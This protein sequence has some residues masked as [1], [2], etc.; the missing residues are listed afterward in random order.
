MIANTI[1]YLSA[2]KEQLNVEALPPL[3]RNRIEW[4]DIAKGIGIILVVMGH[5]GLPKM[6][7]WP[8]FSFHMPL[9]FFISGFLFNAQ[10]KYSFH[11]FL[12]K[13]F[14]SLIVPYVSFS[15]ITILIMWSM[16]PTVTNFYS[17]CVE[18][19]VRGWQGFALWF[20]P[21]LFASEIALFLF[22]TRIERNVL[23]LTV[24]AIAAYI[25]ALL[26]NTWAIQLPFKLDVVFIAL[27]FLC[28]GN[29]ARVKVRNLISL[30][31]SFLLPLC[32]CCVILICFLNFRQVD[33]ANN[34]LGNVFIMPI[35]AI[36]GIFTVILFS[37]AIANSNYKSI[38]AIFSFFG[39]NTLIILAVHQPIMEVINSSLKVALLSVPIVS[40]LIRQMLLWL[41]LFFSARLVNNRLSFLIGRF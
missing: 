19:F 40:I 20:L 9:F 32:L 28:V 35:A 23:S 4:A 12:K 6:L 5:S 36:A 39:V 26:L 11:V 14:K 17:L 33:L 30:N 25:F 21:V 24:F 1:A 13:R 15:V 3:S 18:A 34:E 8:I 16:S 10:E 37:S 2:S 29:I 7:Q 31:K 38:K 22:S 41:M 27:S